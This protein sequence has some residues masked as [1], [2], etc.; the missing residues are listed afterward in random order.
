[1]VRDDD[2]ET[3]VVRFLAPKRNKA[4]NDKGE[5]LFRGSFI[6]FICRYICVSDKDA[7]AIVVVSRVGNLPFTYT[8]TPSNTK[9]HLTKRALQMSDPDSRL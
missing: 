1:M 2:I 7:H 5:P 3:K 9:L 4:F 8:S 6:K